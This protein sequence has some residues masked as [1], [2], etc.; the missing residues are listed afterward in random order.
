MKQFLRMCG[1]GAIIACTT[2]SASL[3]DNPHYI[4][5]IS[6]QERA[7]VVAWSELYW[8]RVDNNGIAPES[9]FSFSNPLMNSQLF[10]PIRSARTTLEYLG[11]ISPSLC[12]R[13]YEFPSVLDQGT[14]DARSAV[15]DLMLY[16]EIVTEAGTPE[17]W[18]H[19]LLVQTIPFEEIVTRW[20]AGEWTYHE[21]TENGVTYRVT[22]DVPLIELG[23]VTA[24]AALQADIS[25]D[26]LTLISSL[27]ATSGYW[28][29]QCTDVPQWQS[30]ITGQKSTAEQFWA[31]VETFL[32]AQ[33]NAALGSSMFNAAFGTFGELPVVAVF[34]EDCF[35]LLDTTNGYLSGPFELGS[36]IDARGLLSV[37]M[38]AYEAGS[39]IRYFSSG[40]GVLG[41]TVNAND[42]EAP[43]SKDWCSCSGATG[44]RI[45]MQCTP[46]A[47]QRGSTC[48]RDSSGND[49]GWCS[50]NSGGQSG[51]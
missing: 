39:P 19:M 35:V 40:G 22:T 11:T 38:D 31:H 6:A 34:L 43:C 21:W 51:N 9:E 8:E 20:V 7:E 29:S 44:T 32:G 48:R 10:N 12:D 3:A 16:G 49:S 14:S 23:G 2:S 24:E 1:I 37:H 50:N 41:T 47:C 42:F 18:E 17:D 30:L 4:A 13:L 46:L 15:R 26:S 27:L 5:G 28:R 36:P 33:G 25:E 45:L